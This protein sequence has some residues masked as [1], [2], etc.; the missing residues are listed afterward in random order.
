MKEFII[1]GIQQM[2]V[3]VTDLQTAWN[4]YIENFGMDCPIFGEEAV[5]NFMLPYTGGEPRSRHAVLAYNL[6]SGGGIEIWQYKSRTPQV[7]DWQPKAGSLGIFSC[8]LKVK[9]INRSY[10][11]LK[12]RNVNL[13]GAPS[14]DPAGAKTFFVKDPFGNIFQMVEGNDWFMNEGKH[15]GGVYGAV[16]GVSDIEKSR[17]V[18]SDI[19]GYDQVVYDSTGVFADFAGLPGGT[20]SLR[21]VLLRRSGKLEGPFS[22]LMGSSEIE[23]ISTGNPG[24][25]KIFEGRFWGDPGFIHLCFDISG[26]DKLRDLCNE[27]GHPFTVDTKKQ[28]E[29]A[30]FDMGEAAGHFSYIEDGD[31]ALIEFVETHK[32]P[33]MKKLG[34]YI[35]LRKRDYRKNLPSWMLRTLSFSKV[36]AKY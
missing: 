1:S 34:W 29:G 16:I 14:A 21:R 31:G 17:V 24:E 25:K 35:D 3:G 26:I 10:E 7:I 6:Q 12:G 9:D 20:A 18:Y 15:S 11:F 33:I 4:W 5:A 23:L 8:K 13:I 2:G 32:V 22:K 28:M 19:L 27:K 36:K 30:S